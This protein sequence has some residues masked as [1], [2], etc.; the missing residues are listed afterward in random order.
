VSLGFLADDLQ[1]MEH[2]EDVQPGFN[3]L[4]W[5]SKPLLHMAIRVS[6]LEHFN[7]GVL[8]ALTHISVCRLGF[9]LKLQLC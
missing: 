4:T 9:V 2:H 6:S 3:P 7:M 1:L 8:N 5:L